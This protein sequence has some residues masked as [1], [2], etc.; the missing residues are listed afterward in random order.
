MSAV[1]QEMRERETAQ[2][3]KLL[4]QLHNTIQ[5]TK[6]YAVRIGEELQEQDAMLGTLQSGVDRTTAETR[7]QNASIL[8][9]LH[10]SNHKGFFL[11]VAILVVIVIMLLLV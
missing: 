1:A 2:Q 3:N 10:E 8:Q 9:Q 11:T 6:S 7:R 5:Q 4:D